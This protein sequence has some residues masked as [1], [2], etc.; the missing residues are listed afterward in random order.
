LIESNLKLPKNYRPEGPSHY[1]GR[2]GEDLEAW[3]FQVKEPNTL[4]P[5]IEEMQRV[6]YDALSFRD[7]AALWYA[8]VQMKDPPEINDWETFVT[9]LRKQFMSE[10]QTFKARNLMKRSKLET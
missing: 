4:F 3:L 1:H 5:I 9:K 6:R 10:D 2:P 8:A 7:T